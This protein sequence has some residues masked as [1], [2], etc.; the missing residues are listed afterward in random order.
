MGVRAVTSAARNGV[1]IKGGTH[2]EAV[3]TVDAVAFD[4]TSTLTHG[5]LTVTDVVPV[6]GESSDAVLQTAASME[7]R[8][9]HPIAEAIVDAA[10]EAGVEPVD[11]SN[12]ESLTGK[13]VR[14]TVD[15]ETQYVGNPGLFEELGVSLDHVHATTDG[16]VALEGQPCDNGEYY[17]L[18]GDTIGNLQREGKTVILVGTAERITGV[19]AVADQV[20]SEAGQ[21][22]NGSTS[23]VSSTS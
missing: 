13:G 15:G 6:N 3:G 22:S 18:E 8:S 23:S 17:D 10:G 21:T 2:L 11:V 16:G 12:F 9:D 19:I 1:L 5:Q 4:K 20:R 7:A 14:A